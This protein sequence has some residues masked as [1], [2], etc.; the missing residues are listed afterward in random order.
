MKLMFYSLCLICS[1]YLIPGNAFSQQIHDPFPKAGASYL[2]QVNG[3]TKWA[4]EPDRRLPLA[5][6]TKIMTSLIVLENCKLDAIVT[7]G[8]SVQLET[9]TKLGLRVGE[10]MS[11]LNLLK[12][13]L[14]YSASDACAALAQHVAGD[15]KRFVEIMNKRAAELG[16]LN[17][18][19]QNCVGHDHKE[20]Y[21][22]AND[23][24]KLAKTALASSIF[25]EIVSTPLDRISTVN[26]K[27]KFVIKNKNEMFKRLQGVKGVKTGYTPEAGKCLVALAERKGTDVLLVLLNSPKR[28]ETADKM[29]EKAFDSAGIDVAS[30]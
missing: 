11:V 9:G 16:L 4:H 13:A 21:S 10:K 26:N 24:A 30:R 28:W 19:F 12:A 14:I 7:V 17:T 5:S 25:S 8:K 15:E 27:R 3:N 20:N 22:T 2:V 6:I 23:I 1:L 29:M 18:H